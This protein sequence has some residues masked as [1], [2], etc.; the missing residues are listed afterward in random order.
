M[1]PKTTILMVLAIGCGLAAAFMTNKLIAE[2]NKENR[3]ED[4][5][6]VLVA[7]KKIPAMTYIKT[8]ADFFEAQERPKG[9]LPRGFL[10]SLDDKDLKDGFRVTKPYSENTVLTRDD[11]FTKE[12]EGLATKVPP[13]MRAVAVRVTAEVIVGGFILPG[14]R[15]DVLWTYRTTNSHVGALTILQNQ[16]V[17]AVDTTAARN[18]ESPQTILGATVTLAVKPEDAQKLSLAAVNGELK[19]SL[20]HV[21]DDKQL[22]LPGT[23]PE[24]LARGSGS[25]EGKK[26]DGTDDTA[27]SAPP[28]VP[29]LPP[30]SAPPPA[31]SPMNPMTPVVTTKPVEPEPPQVKTRVH[32]LRIEDGPHTQTHRFPFD[33]STKSF[34]GAVNKSDFE[35]VS[36]II[37]P[38][39]KPEGGPEAE[40]KP[41]S[42]PSK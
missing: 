13:G 21:S 29:P 16:L 35:T 30:L 18:P 14:S 17:L 27:S 22:Q 9:D 19:L 12:M 10:T 31:T 1:K 26:G 37:K 4:K 33:E 40:N 41:Q 5:V 8:P 23:N 15:V 24:D 7:K 28:V 20:R 3:E 11:V 6:T 39:P 32:I 42:R 38:A 25:D 2:R 34:E 36:P